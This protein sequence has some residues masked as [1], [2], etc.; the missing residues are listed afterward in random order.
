MF[1]GVCGLAIAS[2]A[3]WQDGAPTP[4][5]PMTNAPEQ[6]PQ[7]N[8]P[9]AEAVFERHIE[10]A[11]GRKAAEAI[12]SRTFRGTYRGAPFTSTARVLIH[13]KAPN[14]L[15]IRVQQPAGLLLETGYDG[16]RAWQRIDGGGSRILTG[17]AAASQVESADILGEVNYKERYGEMQTM[18]R[19][20]LPDGSGSGILVRVVSNTTHGEQLLIFSEETGLYAARRG[21]DG[22]TTQDGRTIYSQYLHSDYQEHGGVLFPMKQV[23]LVGPDGGPFN[24]SEIVYR[25]LE[26]NGD[27]AESFDFSIPEPVI[28]PQPE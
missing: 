14:L 4:A 10:A 19:V 23:Q 28:E 16:E 13:Q 3:A 2:A 5:T 20:P 21:T 17:P 6:L 18:A 12:K 24:Q 15:Y 11:G 25:S 1:A 9:D 22:S 27:E 26:V 7:D 8:L